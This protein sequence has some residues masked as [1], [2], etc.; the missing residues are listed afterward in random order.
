MKRFFAVVLLF[1]SMFLPAAEHH[2]LY[3]AGASQA[4]LA[5]RAFASL[6]LP[7]HIHF[8]M[9]PDA[10]DR[11]KLRQAIAQ[12]DLIIANGLVKEFR[13][14]LAAAPKFTGIK[15][16]GARNIKADEEPPKVRI[17]PATQS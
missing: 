17:D 11:E 7:G 15:L 13:E 1:G 9:I 10:S 16:I 5:R 6:K 2:V 3:L 4:P 14:A 12:A 8:T